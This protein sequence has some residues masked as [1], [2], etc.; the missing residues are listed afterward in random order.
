MSG[1]A[2]QS[3][4][5]ERLLHRD[6]PV[7]EQN[8]QA[9]DTILYALGVGAGQGS[10]AWDERHL[11]FV[12]ED[13]LQAL[14]TMC[15]M[16][17]DPGFWMREPDTGLDWGRLVHGEQSMQW[18][19][20]LPPSGETIG[21]NRVLQVEDKGS[22]KG[23][24]FVVERELC[25]ADTGECWVR[26]QMTVVARGNQG[27]DP[28]GGRWQQPGAQAPDPL[29][30]VPQRP[31]DHV[32]LRT[33]ATHL[34]LLYRLSSDL[35]PLHADP[36]VARRAGFERPIMHGMGTFGL[37][38]MLLVC[39]FCDFDASRLAEMRARF[40]APLYPGETLRCEFWEEAGQIRFR[41]TAVERDVVVLDRGVAR[42]L[43]HR[44]DSGET[45]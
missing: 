26:S 31:A 36:A 18:L 23:V 22:G 3:L 24:V 41:G 17:G 16:L 29:P 12:Y 8:Y 21:R 37:L 14:P 33:T 32:L 34:P 43:S 40:T 5:L 4:D 44:A 28:S 27:L 30:A 9:R 7:V 10:D 15:A 11:S 19:K 2:M 20:A 45:Q 39:E 1:S 6:L 42:V 38:G 13:G 35:N 25:A